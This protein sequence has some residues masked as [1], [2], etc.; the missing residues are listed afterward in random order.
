MSYQNIHMGH[1]YTVLAM[2]YGS[3]GYKQNIKRNK[4]TPRQHVDCP[5]LNHVGSHHVTPR[6]WFSASASSWAGS[7]DSLS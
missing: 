4:T 1:N 2:Y 5:E 6:T 3:L 7:S